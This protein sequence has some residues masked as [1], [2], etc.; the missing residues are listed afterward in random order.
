MARKAAN[1][2]AESKPAT[3]KGRQQK[4]PGTEQEDIDELDGIADDLAEV[5]E[6]QMVARNRESQLRGVMLEAMKKHGRT[7][8]ERG[9]MRFEL[10]STTKLKIKTLKDE[11]ED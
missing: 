5:H 3:R 4:V 1:D 7:V 6:D 9:G 11:S 2:T 10:A 8:Y